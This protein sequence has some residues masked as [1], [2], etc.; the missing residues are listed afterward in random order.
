V[1]GEDGGLLLRV[2]ST[3]GSRLCYAQAPYQ[4]EFGMGRKMLVSRKALNEIKRLVDS[5][6]GE[7]CIGFGDR[8]ITV[9]VGSSVLH[10]RLVDGEFP[11]YRKVLPTVQ[12]RRAKIE[13]VPFLDALKRVA[14]E[15]QDKA[16]TVRLKF[17]VDE[18]VASA[19]SVEHGEARH[20]VPI[21]FQGSSIQV[22]FNVR[23]FLDVVSC[24]NDA[25]LEL[26]F[27]EALSPCIIRPLDREDALFVVMPI[28]LD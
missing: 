8:T 16:S 1:E 6:E 7:A 10:A 28:R 21:D 14:L 24:V 25:F 20:P 11:P 2:V 9:T 5:G 12:S 18:L 23:F 19:R 22:G 15:A 13:R 27:D 26:R 3:D 17:D 4:G